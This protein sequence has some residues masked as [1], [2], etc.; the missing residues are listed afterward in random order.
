MSTPVPSGV[1]VGVGVDVDVGPQTW[2]SVHKSGAR[3]R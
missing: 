1:G 3:G 2:K